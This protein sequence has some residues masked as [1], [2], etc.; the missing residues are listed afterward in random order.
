MSTT[1]IERYA[2]VDVSK[3]R[4]EVAVR[5]TGERYSVANDPEGIDTLV[6]RLEEA[7]PPKLVVLEATGGLERPAAMALAGS[8]I[9]VAVVNPR[10]SEGLRQGDR[11]PGQNRPNRRLCP[12]PLRRGAQA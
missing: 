6:G 3:T 5:S 10:A 7:G 1:T 4:L 8:G 12:R 11:H 2:G 9:A